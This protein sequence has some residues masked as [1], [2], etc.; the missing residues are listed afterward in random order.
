MLNFTIKQGEYF[1]VGKDI[2]IVFLGGTAHNYRVMIEAPKQYNIVRGKALEK[3]A[4]NTE[5]R[6]K[7][8]QYYPEPDIPK[9][10]MRKIMAKQ[11]AEKKNGNNL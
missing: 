1:M 7:L 3:Y 8:K 6:E 4:K 9:E 2:R 10:E 11:K 5:E